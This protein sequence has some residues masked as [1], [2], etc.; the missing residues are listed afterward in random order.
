MVD[1]FFTNILVGLIIGLGFI[2]PGVSGG[3][4][5]AIMGVYDKI[6]AS[7]S[8][9]FHDFKKNA[10]YLFPFIIGIISG[11]LIFSKLL[12]FLLDNH[13]YFIS[14]VFIGLIIGCIPYLFKKIKCQE[15]ISFMAM[16]LAFIFG[17]ILFIIQKFYPLSYEN[18]NIIIWIIGGVFYAIGK[19]VPGISGAAL[20]MLIGLY[21]PLLRIIANPTSINMPIIGKLIP[22]F[23]A[24]LISSVLIIKTINHLLKKHFNHTYS[25]IIGFTISSILF[26]IPD[27][28]DIFSPIIIILAFL[29]SYN[30]SN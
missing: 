15:K 25:A 22:F 3:V 9:L 4:L 19:L 24:F 12:L 6:I 13:K 16:V 10:W 29:I 14:Y 5:A 7:L 1:I 23:L 8:N 21:E 11:I 26:I 28:F 18:T 2:I 17:L 27:S 30:L 20:L